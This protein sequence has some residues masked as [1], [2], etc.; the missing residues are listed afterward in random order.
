MFS[1]GVIYL[2]EKNQVEST[3]VCKECPYGAQCIDTKLSSKPGFWG[4]IKNK[5]VLFFPCK[6]GHCMTCDTN[7]CSDSFDL[8][9]SHRHGPICTECMPNYTE[10]LFSTNCVPD[11]QCTNYWFWPTILLLAVFYSIFLMFHLDV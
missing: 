9:S 11:E 7:C 5:G 4:T 1:F 3:Q 6:S 10:A 8:C 2:K